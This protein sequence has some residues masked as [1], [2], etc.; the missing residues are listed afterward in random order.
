[1]SLS[2]FLSVYPPVLCV[3]HHKHVKTTNDKVATV[4][5]LSLQSL[6]QTTDCCLIDTHYDTELKT[7]EK[8]LY[9]Y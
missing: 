6:F 8:I 2:T 3:Q 4:H 5:A 1:M 7:V 9:V